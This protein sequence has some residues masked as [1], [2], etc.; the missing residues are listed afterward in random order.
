MMS[1][2]G[3]EIQESILKERASSGPVPL[4]DKKQLLGLVDEIFLSRRVS[5]RDL[6]T[7]S[8]PMILILKLI[9]EVLIENER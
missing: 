9:L 6:K 1:I 2:A 5:V 3:K 7:V 4:W 8:T